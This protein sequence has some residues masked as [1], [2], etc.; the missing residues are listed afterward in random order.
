MS[1]KW[2]QDTQL[3]P[4]FEQMEGEKNSKAEL[5]SPVSKNSNWHETSVTSPS[6]SLEMLLRRLRAVEDKQDDKFAKV[7]HAVG[8]FGTFQ[9]RLV[10]L[11]FIPNILA[12]FFMFVDHFTLVEQMP[13]CNTSWILAVGPNLSEAEQLNLTLP[14]APNGSFLT[15]LMYLPVNWDLDSIIQFGLNYTDTCQHGWIYPNSKMRS[16]INEVCF[17]LGCL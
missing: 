7:L 9:Q 17:V 8:D 12:A 11:T 4:F 16:L 13:Y 10:A 1:G 15:C 2:C 3:H 14:R 6:W 5:R